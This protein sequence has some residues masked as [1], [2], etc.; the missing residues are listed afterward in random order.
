MGHEYT[1]EAEGNRIISVNGKGCDGKII[2]QNTFN[3]VAR[4]KRP[5]VGIT[6]TMTV[7]NLSR[8][9]KTG[10]HIYTN[11]ISWGEKRA[12]ERRKRGRH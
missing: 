4:W 3:I 2:A 5:P 6:G 1:I 9:S 7:F 11:E 10:E 12:R 8:I